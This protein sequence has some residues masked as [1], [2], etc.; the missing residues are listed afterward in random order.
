MTAFRDRMVLAIQNHKG[1]EPIHEE[2]GIAVLDLNLNRHQPA[3][4]TVR[5][6]HDLPFE[7]LIYGNLDIKQT[8][9]AAGQ[10]DVITGKDDRHGQ[11]FQIFTDDAVF[12]LAALRYKQ[13]AL[14]EI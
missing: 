4:I 14:P 12:M 6:C 1:M 2:A 9:I 13:F 11:F 5:D 10:G 7:C 3:V 8:I